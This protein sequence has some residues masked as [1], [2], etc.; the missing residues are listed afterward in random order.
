MSSILPGNPT[1]R[2][3][4]PMHSLAAVREARASTDPAHR[5]QGWFLLSTAVWRWWQP[6]SKAGGRDSDGE[7][8]GQEDAGTAAYMWGD[9]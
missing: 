6:G 2:T 8:C 7:G 4:T 9:K 1:L 3:L 5:H